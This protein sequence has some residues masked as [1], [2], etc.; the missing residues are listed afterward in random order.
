MK[1]TQCTT[2]NGF[3]LHA[4]VG[5]GARARDRL[6]QLIKDMTRPPISNERLSLMSSPP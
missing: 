5:V 6:L 3:N 2:I 1:G 4:K